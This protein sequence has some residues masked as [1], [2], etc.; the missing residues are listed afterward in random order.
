[1]ADDSKKTKESARYC[2][3]HSAAKLF[4]KKGLDKTSTRDIAQESKV[5]ISMISYHFGGK[6]GLYKQ[7]LMDFAKN[8]ESGSTEILETFAGQEMTKESFYKEMSAIINHMIQTRIKNPEICTMLSRDKIEGMPLSQE[9]H[10]QIFYPLILKFLDLMAAAQSKK[11]VKADVNP[12]LFF[13][14]MSEGIFGFFEVA[15]CKTKIADRSAG[16]VNEPENLKNQ[17]V[18]IYLEGILL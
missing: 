14:L 3:L 6:E 5:N 15:G 17:I 4:C 9:I 12:T 7:V 8:I 2:L 1:M 18:K 16:L 10:E 13:I 11:I